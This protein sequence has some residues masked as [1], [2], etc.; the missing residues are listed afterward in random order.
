MAE[1]SKAHAWKVCIGQKPIVGSNPTLSA[2]NS[3]ESGGCRI[4]PMILSPILES[5]GVCVSD[6]RHGHFAFKV[7]ALKDR[8]YEVRTRDAG[9][10]LPER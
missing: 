7:G 5:S 8:G 3:M 4:V 2:N 6:G 9:R 10:L 1:R